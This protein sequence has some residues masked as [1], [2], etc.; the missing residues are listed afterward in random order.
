[1]PAIYAVSC[2]CPMFQVNFIPSLVPDWKKNCC[3]AL[4]I[5]LFAFWSTEQIARLLAPGHNRAGFL[6]PFPWTAIRMLWE[7]AEETGWR[8]SALIVAVKRCGR[9][10]ITG[11]SVLCFKSKKIDQLAG[12]F[13][14][15]L[16]RFWLKIKVIVCIIITAWNKSPT[17]DR[18]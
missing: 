17:G 6:V 12:G 18:L 16:N 9:F 13:E 4:T 3:L 2:D 7:T 14:F 5:F 1:M 15:H 11:K 8:N 10:I